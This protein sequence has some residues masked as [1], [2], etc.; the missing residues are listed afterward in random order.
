MK[1]RL[2]AVIGILAL[3]TAM[4]PVAVSAAPPIPDYKPVDVGPELRTW[5]AS[6]GRIQGG[7]NALTP[8]E[9]NAKKAEAM[10]ALAG[11]PYADCAVDAKSWLSLDD[12]NGLYFFTTFYLVSETA[13]SELW[14]QANL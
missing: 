1:T 9:A 11:T 4:F 3:L 13:G 10:A 8:D 14:V 12:V 2:F 6:P 7:P 5:E